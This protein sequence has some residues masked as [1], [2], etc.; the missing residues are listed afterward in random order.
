MKSINFHLIYIL[1]L[2]VL[3]FLSSCKKDIAT[4]LH[5]MYGKEI[6]FDYDRMECVDDYCDSIQIHND[7]NPYNL[8]VYFDS[9]ECMSCVTS[10]L[11]N[12]DKFINELETQSPKVNVIF[13]FSPQ[14]NLYEE[15]KGAILFQKFKYPIWMDKYHLFIN[16]N[17]DV[18]PEEVYYHTF[19]INNKNKI[20]F[21]GDPRR[22]PELKRL[23]Y[24]SIKKDI[25]IDSQK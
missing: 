16:N 1:L 14:L 11:H 13:L 10:R 2:F 19:L 7:N 23:F 18:I 21:V 15:V 9:L 3:L 6:I 25:L 17:H 20:I 5:E 4:N 22:S 12:W 24:A 8:V